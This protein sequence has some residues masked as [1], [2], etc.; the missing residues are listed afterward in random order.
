MFAKLR[1]LTLPKKVC[2]ARNCKALSIGR[3]GSDT[4]LGRS[5]QERLKPGS[6]GV[7]PLSTV[8]AISS[9][10]WTLRASTVEPFRCAKTFMKSLVLGAVRVLLKGGSGGA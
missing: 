10:P 9:E 5:K 4:Q 6:N 7:I 2:E 3:Q 8:T 1:R